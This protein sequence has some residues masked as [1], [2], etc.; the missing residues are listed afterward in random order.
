VIGGKQRTA[1]A[2]AGVHQGV[3]TRVEGADVYVEVP[4]LSPGLE[5]GPV[6]ACE[7]ATPWAPAQAVLVACLEGRRDELAIVCRLG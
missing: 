1:P 4:R 7:V 6:L 5:Y 2:G 3:V